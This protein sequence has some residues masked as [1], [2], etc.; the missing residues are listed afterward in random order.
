MSAGLAMTVR[1]FW[2]RRVQFAEVLSKNSSLTVSRYLRLIV[3]CCVEMACTVPLGAF[4]IYINNAGLHI[5]KWISWSNTHYN[6]SFVEIFPAET[7]ENRRAFYV[8]V[9]MGRWI[10]P[11]SAILFF[12]LFGFASEARRNYRI[13]YLWICKRLGITPRTKSFGKDL[14]RFVFPPC[15]SEHPHLKS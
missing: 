4:S 10:Y 6:F 1:I 13:A 15:F 9:Q 14:S 7:W 12:A 5:A 3:L 2:K 8:S 11:C